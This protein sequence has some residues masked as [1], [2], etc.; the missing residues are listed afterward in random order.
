MKNRIVNPIKMIRKKAEKQINLIQKC[1]L[2][3]IISVNK[4][5]WIIDSD[6]LDDYLTEELYKDLKTK[7]K[8]VDKNFNRKLER[9]EKSE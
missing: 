6:Y 1:L 9:L 3:L 4:D 7:W 5:L 8:I 2:E